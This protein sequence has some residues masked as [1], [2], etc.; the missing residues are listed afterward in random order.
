MARGSQKN[1]SEVRARKSVPSPTEPVELDDQ[2]NKREEEGQPE[3]YF[4]FF[5]LY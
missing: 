4:I 1:A 3:R 2:V 5:T